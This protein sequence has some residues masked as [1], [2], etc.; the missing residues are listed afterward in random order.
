MSMLTWAWVADGKIAP[1]S[2]RQNTGFFM[3]NSLTNDRALRKE[4]TLA[5]IDSD[6]SGGNTR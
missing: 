3:I 6:Q 2:I 5:C 1:A 4:G